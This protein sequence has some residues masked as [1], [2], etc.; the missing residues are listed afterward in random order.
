MPPHRQIP[1]QLLQVDAVGLIAAQDRLNDV[2]RKRRK[3]QQ[4][5][6]LPGRTEFYEPL[7]VLPVVGSM[8]PPPDPGHLP[9]LDP[10][11]PLLF[12]VAVAGDGFI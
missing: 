9:L 5:A 1:P 4:P 7:P 3:A 12:V 8:I 11:A 6:G 2:R 10:H